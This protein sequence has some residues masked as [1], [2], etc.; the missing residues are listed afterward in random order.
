LRAQCEDV[1]ELLLIKDVIAAGV[2]SG[3]LR[4]LVRAGELRHLRRGAYANEISRTTQAE[5]LL[6][7]RSAVAFAESDSVVSF[8]SAALLHGLPVP[9][10]ALRSVHLTKIR[11]S[12]GR[13]RP[14]V[15]I[16]VAPLSS[17]EIVE[18]DGLPV[19]SLDR[20]F[21]DYSRTAGLHNAVAS[22]DVALLKGMDA[23]AVVDQ[24]EM[25]KFRHG[26]RTARR[27]AALIDARSESVA[28]SISR[29]IMIENGL[30][31]PELQ[32]EIAGPGGFS[33]RV[34]FLWKDLGVV[35]E[36]DG[37]IKYGRSLQ[38]RDQPGD[39]A[40]REKIREDRLRELGYVVVRWVWDD[41]LHPE[42]LVARIRRAFELAA[43]VRR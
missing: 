35:G 36:F 7:V 16:H 31:T 9:E 17:A 10:S 42:R 38:D 6:L 18:I 39:A 3:E 27:A 33:A 20:T 11:N 43:H 12:G 14:G 13:R 25:A 15:H 19:S 8:G 32:V 4:S 1:N 34:D 22:G 37:K 41:L 40:F 21:V 23:S 5:H 30:P 29:V 2:E 28:E 24:L 26:V